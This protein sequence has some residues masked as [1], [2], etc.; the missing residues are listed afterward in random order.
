MGYGA[1][2]VLKGRVGC[3]DRVVWFDDRGRDLGGW[4]HGELEFRF[5]CVIDGQTFE[6]ESTESGPCA[7]TERVEDKDTLETV[8]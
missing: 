6:E 2:S 4:V 1:I 3:Q 7:T 8:A 5:F